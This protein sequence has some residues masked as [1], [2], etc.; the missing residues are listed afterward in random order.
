MSTQK[1]IIVWDPDRTYEL[2]LARRLNIDLFDNAEIIKGTPTYDIKNDPRKNIVIKNWW[3]WHGTTETTNPKLDLSWADLVVCYTGEVINGPWE[4]YYEKTIN[5]FNNKN[6]V[7]VSSGILNLPK[8]PNHIVYDDLGHFMSKI[9]DVCRFEDWNISEDKPKLFDVLLGNAKPHRIFIFNQLQKHGLLDTSF[10]NIHE[11]I[12]NNNYG[13]VNYKSPDL[14]LYDD[15]SITDADRKQNMVMRNGLYN[16]ISVSHSIP[17][18]IYQN[19]WYSIVAETNGS[20][21]NFI[22]EKTAKPI[23]SKKLFVMFGAQGLLQK[24]HK[25]GY[26]TFHGVIDENYDNEPDDVKRWSMAFEQVIKLAT[27]NHKEIYNEIESILTH[28]HNHTCD[29]H[30]RLNGL[31]NFFNQHLQLGDQ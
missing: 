30:Y 6:F 11:S 9:A 5:Q 24:L 16:G 25:Q 29:H 15:P 17:L 28:N 22:T 12:Y 4:W 3:L 19:S 27:A 21:S 26:K 31:K 23:F 7:S 18:K 20:Y 1:K 8:F 2:S 10:V 13:S 14:E